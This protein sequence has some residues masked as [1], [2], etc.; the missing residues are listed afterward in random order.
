MMKMLIL[1]TLCCFLVGF[2]AFAQDDEKEKA[3]VTAEKETK[4]VNAEKE[5]AAVAAAEKWLAMIDAGQYEASWKACAE[6]FRNAVTSEQWDQSMKAARVPLGKLISRKVMSKS[7]SNAL[8]GAP[9]GEYVVIQFETVFENKKSS[10]ETVT[11]MLE[12]DGEWHVSGY[13]IK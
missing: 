2:P 3:A 7:Y 10:I 13:F 6:L 5:T 11:P 8:P 4:A 1:M 12:K 9:D